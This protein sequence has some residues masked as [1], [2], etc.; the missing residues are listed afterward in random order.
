MDLSIGI[1][2]AASAAH[3]VGSVLSD[4][5]ECLSVQN[6]DI[7]SIYAEVSGHNSQPTS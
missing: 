4:E 1:S 5:A 6:A 2:I 7:P 3:N